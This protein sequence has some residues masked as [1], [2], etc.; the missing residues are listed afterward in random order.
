MTGL[1]NLGVMAL[2][3]MA[4]TVSAAAP[5]ASVRA[6]CTPDAK[7]LCGAVIGNPEARHKCMVEHRAQLSEAC[8]TA[9]AEDKKAAGA[10]A[11]PPAA[12]DPSKTPA[13]PAT[14]AASPSDTK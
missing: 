9:L 5:S 8:K 2:I 3:V 4:P 12:A 10:A 1:R 13:P 11:T 14:S 7:R 6:A